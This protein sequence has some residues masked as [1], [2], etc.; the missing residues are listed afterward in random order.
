MCL[1]LFYVL[2]K[3]L[4][5]FLAYF[6]LHTVV[7]FGIWPNRFTLNIK[8]KTGSACHPE[9]LNTGCVQ[10]RHLFSTTQHKKLSGLLLQSC[11]Y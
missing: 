6:L 4:L 9:E 3:Y 2:D 10:P 5:N 8:K 7:V 11:L 1:G